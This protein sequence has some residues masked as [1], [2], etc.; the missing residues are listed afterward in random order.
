MDGNKF[1][2]EKLSNTNFESWKFNVQMLLIRDELWKYVEDA[3]PNP[4]TDAW[5]KGDQKTRATIAL[6]VGANQ[7]RLIQK[8]TTAKQTW[9]ALVSHHQKSSITSVLAMLRRVINMQY[10]E[11][12]DLERHLIEMENLF[13]RIANAGYELP[14]KITMLMV[15]RSMLESYDNLGIAMENRP[16]AELTEPS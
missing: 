13:E 5:K 15:L 2:I 7:R 12:D 8:C 6:L 11:G 1:T 10:T 16:D 4:E 3:A 14:A 9:E